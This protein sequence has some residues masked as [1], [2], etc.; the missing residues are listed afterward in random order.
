MPFC[1]N[2]RFEYLPHV[3]RC[4]ECGAELVAELPPLASRPRT[5]ED[6]EPELLCVV[7]GSIHAGLLRT[8][9]AAR[10]IPSRLQGGWSDDPLLGAVGAVPPPL[11]S[12]E[13]GLVAVFVNRAD[14]E[15]AKIIYHDLEELEFE[16]VEEPEGEE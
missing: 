5:E 2:C 11:G 12:A 9:L 15:R 13:G 7:G 10:G 16:Y 14:L 3:T 6:F 4:P 8:E 1:A